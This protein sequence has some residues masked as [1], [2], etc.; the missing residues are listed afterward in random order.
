M[1]IKKDPFDDDDDDKTVEPVEAEEQEGPVKELPVEPDPNEEA[2]A[3]DTEEVK[4]AR[5]ERRQNRFKEA[6]ASAEAEKARADAAERQLNEE[7]TARI[8]TETAARTYVEANRANQP[9]YDPWQVAADEV[10]TRRL[11]LANEVKILTAEGKYDA[12]QQQ[13]LLGE[14]T[15]TEQRLNDISVNKQLYYR[16]QQQRQYAPNHQ[17]QAQEA[18]VGAQIQTRYPDVVAN[19]Q[20]ARFMEMTFLRAVQAEGRPNNWETADAAAAEARRA[21]KLGRP[22]PADA[23]T[24]ARYSGISAG[25]NGSANGASNGKIGMTSKYKA[26]AHTRFPDLSEEQAEKKWAQ[27]VGKKILSN[28]G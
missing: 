21:F 15:A 22:P 4:A 24:K 3:G 5:R 17:A 11:A 6:Q 14:W 19:P 26:M 28:G 16:D 8:A 27:T 13:R 20:A 18:A 7:R 1:A 23:A 2:S 25:S 10:K 9:Q 12:E